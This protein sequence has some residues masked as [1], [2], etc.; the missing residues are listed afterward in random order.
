[1]ISPVEANRRIDKVL[2]KRDLGISRARL[3]RW[4]EE[5]RVRVDGEPVLAKTKVVMGDVVRIVPAPVEPSGVVPQHIPLDIVYE[6]EHLLVLNKP[7]G[8]V[9]HPAPGH[10]QGTLVNGLLYHWNVTASEAAPRAGI[11]HR[12]D[13]DTSGLMVVAK[14]AFVHEALVQA[15]QERLIAREYEAIVVGILP[16]RAMRIETLYGRHP[17]HRKRFSSQVERGKIAITNVEVKNALH[18]SSWLRCRLETG[19]THQIRVHLADRGF[20]VLADSTYGKVPH[21]PTLAR[22]AIELG[23]QALH[24]TVLGFAHPI[25]KQWLLFHTELPVPFL[26]ALQALGA[27]QFTDG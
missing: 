24:A 16:E 5:G 13:K 14:A 21:D 7:A 10:A 18:G 9:V 20:P 3:Q 26:R 11:V 27:E 17:I 1:M 8:L 25:S 4:I 6:D 19:R 2:A 22:A 15:F 12:L 23:R